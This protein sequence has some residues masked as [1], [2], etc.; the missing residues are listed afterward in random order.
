MT[1]KKAPKTAHIA[2]NRKFITRRSG[3]TPPWELSPPENIHYSEMCFLLRV[4]EWARLL[5]RKIGAAAPAAS[6]KITQKV[7]KPL[8]RISCKYKPLA[9]ASPKC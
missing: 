2:A 4:N 8:R 7:T 1:E 5:N 3:L 9:A 6:M